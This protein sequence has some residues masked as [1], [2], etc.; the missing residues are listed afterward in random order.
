MLPLITCSNCNH[1]FTGEFCNQCG[2][3]NSHRLTMGHL[4]HDVV[5]AITHADKGF[6]HLFLQLFYKPGVVAKEYIIE[7]KR[8]RYFLPFQYLVI[9][10][11]IATFVAVNSHFFDTTAQFMTPEMSATTAM[12]QEF[13]LKAKEFQTRYYN[14]LILIQL[15][16]FALASFWVFKKQRLYFAEHLTLQT[17][18]IAQTAVFGMIMMLFMSLIKINQG[19]ML[20]FMSLISILYQ[21]L[22][23]KQFFGSTTSNS[24]LKGLAAYIVGFLLFLIFIILVSFIV[25]VIM[26]ANKGA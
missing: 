23:Y 19:Y 3:K 18:L 22:A 9:I 2:Q 11:A 16:F 14:L 4:A 5:H 1:A 7:G 20:V 24:M 6:F 21:I 26:V 15:P 13:M 10:S 8:K 25:V 17:F 12:Q